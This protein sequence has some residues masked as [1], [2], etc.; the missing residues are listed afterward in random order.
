MPPAI[1]LLAALAASIVD[2]DGFLEWATTSHQWIL[3]HFG[4]LFSLGAIS[5][6]MLMFAVYCSPLG[7]VRIGGKAAVPIL[8]RWNWFAITLC[9]TIATGILFWGTAEPLFHLN[10]PPDFSGVEARSEGAARF[11][12]STVYLHWSIT[13]YAIYSV[14]AL[15]FALAYHNLGKSYSLSAPLSMV[16]GPLARNN[17]AAIIDAIALFALVAG[18][19]GSLGA[20]IMTLVGG[21][22]AIAG[23]PD[24]IITRFIITVLI[25]LV[26]VASSISGLQ[27]GIKLLSDINIRF[28]FIFA[29]FIFVAG[30]TM[31]IL[32][33]GGAS[34][35]QY[36]K[37]FFPR[38]F[39]FLGGVDQW[40]RDWTI[41]F[42]ANWLAWAPVTALFLGRIAVGYTVREFIW[43]NLLLP[44]LFGIIWMTIFGVAAIDA[45]AAGGVL[46][47]VLNNEGPEGVAYA[48]FETL[49]F[50]GVAMITF[51]LATFI[52]FVTAMDSNTHSIVNLCLRGNQVADQPKG[53]GLW[54]KIFWGVLIGAIAWIM[55]ATTGIEGIR[56]LVNLGGG[57]GLLIIIG[58]GVALIRFMLM[59]KAHLE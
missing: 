54:L 36:G 42:F 40:T 32:T 28:F 53:T 9:T 44:S 41:F 14:P 37:D 8:K 12:L 6:V 33:M 18:V 13:P 39:A 21:G 22:G 17:G 56:M 48:L 4:W 45:D 57:P 59:K 29:I 43:F 49:P 10:A 7:G 46:T 5:A 51:V 1:V 24:N 11:A 15:A 3:R 27:R 47:K 16:I 38:S 19:A 58:C 34:V 30:P 50:V 55:T 31:L 2:F 26:F 35:V 52:S 25:V 20:G 23:V